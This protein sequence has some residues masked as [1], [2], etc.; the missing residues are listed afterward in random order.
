MCLPRPPNTHTR[1]L[2]VA[3]N[4]FDPRIC[5]SYSGIIDYGCQISGLKALPACAA[6]SPGEEG[7]EWGEQHAGTRHTHTLAH[8]LTCQA[9]AI[10]CRQLP[11]ILH[12]SS[13]RIIVAI[14][15][16]VCVRVC[17]H[18]HWIANVCVCVWAHTAEPQQQQQ[19]R[20]PRK[21]NEMRR[22][23][24]RIAYLCV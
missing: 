10:L 3:G 13:I 20:R 8:T 21:R 19:Q 2:T 6:Q 22:V 23:L 11:E 1:P 9:G 12:A 18:P 16:C 17:E 15:V 7:G 5:A 14:V 4:T 24:K